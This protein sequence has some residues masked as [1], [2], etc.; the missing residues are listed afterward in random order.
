MRF[1]KENWE[2]IESIYFKVLN[3]KKWI[4]IKEVENI[5]SKEEIEMLSKVYEENKEDIDFHNRY[6]SKL[7][8]PNNNIFKTLLALQSLI[9]IKDNRTIEQ[10]LENVE[11]NWKFEDYIYESCKN[12]GYS[13]EKTGSDKDR[14]H[15]LFNFNSNP[16]LKINGYEVEVQ[17][18]NNCFFKQNKINTCISQESY[19]L[20]YLDREQLFY[21][22]NTSEI[23]EID[24]QPEVTLYGF[25]KGKIFDKKKYN[26]RKL[27]EILEVLKNPKIIK[28][29]ILDI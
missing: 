6:T 3:N 17:R 22:F 28:Q 4:D 20:Y 21:L 12:L 27:E 11:K 1:L 19:I 16:D 10:L 2:K 8:T 26:F 18:G 9:Y 15:S 23:I 25:K 7:K 24:N 29:Q 14:K 13:I 5:L